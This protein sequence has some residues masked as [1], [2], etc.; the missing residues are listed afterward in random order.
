MD[1][2]GRWLGAAEVDLEQSVLDWH[3]CLDELVS[4]AV[5]FGLQ[6]FEGF[7]YLLP[8]PVGFGYD[9]EVDVVDFGSLSSDASSNLD[10]LTVSFHL[11]FDVFCE[12]GG[13][14]KVK[15]LYE[16]WCVLWEKC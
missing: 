10:S 14:L 4:R 5:W 2:E 13:L 3:V 1:S 15:F 11:C 7:V 16:G 9:D 12:F 6:A 8:V